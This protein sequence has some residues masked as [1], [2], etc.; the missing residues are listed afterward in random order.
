MQVAVLGPL[1]VSVEARSIPVSGTRL[2]ALLLRL[3]VDAGRPVSGSELADAVW[4]ANRPA[5]EANALQTLV[6]RLRRALGDPSVLAQHGQGYRLVG[7]DTDVAQFY[8]LIELAR[9]ATSAGD[10]ATAVTEYQRALALWR[11]PALDGWGEADWALGPVARWQDDQLAA[12]AARIDCEVQLGRSAQV[13]AELEQLCRRY[14]MREQFTQT[15]M[16]ALAATGR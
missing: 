2:R 7:V 5:D 10:L 13:I 11:G 8:R 3:A 16:T 4:A 1:E 15:L 12:L 9:T 6:S 14:P